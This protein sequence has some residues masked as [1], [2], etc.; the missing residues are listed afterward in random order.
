MFDK[1]S[2]KNKN[3][4]LLALSVAL[5]YL[6]YKLAIIKTVGVYNDYSYLRT[7]LVLAQHIDK[8]SEEMAAKLNAVESIF[9]GS[10]TNGNNSQEKILETVS[11]YCKD[12]PV[13]LKEFPRSLMKENNGYL[14]ELNYFTVQGNYTDLLNL[15]Y[16]MEQKVKTG[17]VASVNFQLKENPKSHIKELTA[18]IY[19]QNIKRIDV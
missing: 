12:K 14:I 4:V 17:K 6:V 3:R 19:I 16:A 2:Y 11:V 10:M 18:T 5:L 9:K 1:L 8:K 13:L 7:Q 15:V